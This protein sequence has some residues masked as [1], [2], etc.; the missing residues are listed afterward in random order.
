M[1]QNYLFDT[2]NEALPGMMGHL[3]LDGRYVP[4]RNG[5][6]KELA[7]TGITIVKPQH[8]EILNA[9]RKHNL[10][11]QIA[12]TMWVLAG[13][14][15]VE[16]LGRYLPRAKDF[17]DN[18]LTWRAGYGPRLRA[19]SPR[20]K[21]EG[22][23]QLEYVVDLLRK[24]PGTR[25]AV[26]SIWNPLVDTEPGKDI[27]CNNWLH[28]LSREGFLDLHVAVRSNDAMWGWSWVS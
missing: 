3:L 28:F 14:N 11:A 24:D 19:F 25:Q 9:A 13:R 16:W 6:T 15:D 7:F 2:I 4:S 10:A 12:E 26:M 5:V 23:D 22:I 18:G 1:R 27:A 8:R 17:S 21:L 20:R